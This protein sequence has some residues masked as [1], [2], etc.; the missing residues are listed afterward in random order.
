MRLFKYDLW[1]HVLNKLV[2]VLPD[3]WYIYLRFKHR[4]G[5]WPHLSNPRSFNEKLQW[6]K[7]NYHNP[8]MQQL[9]DKLAV[10]EYIKENIGEVC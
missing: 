6:L 1:G 9:V 3:E 7:L 8:I 4:V 10:R 2:Y 5:Y